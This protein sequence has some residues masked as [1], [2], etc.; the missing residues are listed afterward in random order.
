MNI[1]IITVYNSSNCGSYLQAFGMK[2]F[3]ESHG[4]NVSFVRT[5]DSDYVKNLFYNNSLFVRSIIKYPVIGVQRYLFYKKKYQI[6][7]EESEKTFDVVSVNDLK[8]FDIIVLGSDEIWNVRT[9]VFQNELFYGMGNTNVIA[10]AVSAGRSEYNDYQENTKS[11][12]KKIKAIMPR[13]INTKEIVEKITGKEVSCVCDPTMLIDVSIYE[14]ELPEVLNKH[15]YLLIYAYEVSADL[16]KNIKRYAKK[17]NLKIVSAGFYCIWADYNINCKSI[18]LYTMAKNAEAVVT[19]TFHGTIFSILSRNRFV[20][21]PG[22]SINKVGDLLNR[23]GLQEHI[24][25]ET[26]SYEKF[27][28]IISKS[29]NYEDVFAKI[30]KYRSD[31]AELFLEQIERMEHKG[32]KND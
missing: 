2:K 11:L 12:I 20:S 3:L 32:D 14:T 25:S 24:L 27:E 17:H 9:K 19:T 4:H 26:E 13:D 22:Q 28:N 18:E 30:D 8:K 1:G 7:K 21:I 16:R 10:Y 15:K 23:F 6:F 29:I 31:S 5:R